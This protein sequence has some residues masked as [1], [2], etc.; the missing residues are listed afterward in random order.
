MIEP[1]GHSLRSGGRR[2]RR[3]SVM[4]F[5]L[6][7]IVV[8]AAA[9]LAF[10][11]RAL[12]EMAG[13][14]Y[15]IQRSR[16]RGEAYSALEATL[17]VLADFR[18]ID[19]GIF[20]PAQGWSDPLTYAGYQ[21]A[22]G[23]TVTVEFSDENAKLALQH[24]DRNEAA[25]IALFTDLGFDTKEVEILTD[26]LLDWIDSDDNPRPVGAEE[27]EYSREDPAYVPA[28]RA[29]RTFEELAAVRGF[30]DLMFTDTGYPTP[31]FE[32]FKQRT[33][34]YGAGVLNLNTASEDV[35]RMSGLFGDN[36]LAALAS[37]LDTVNGPR[38]SAGARFYKSMQD[39]V[40]QTGPLPAGSAVSV[41]CQVLNILITVREGQAVFRLRAVI[42]TDATGTSA[43]SGG[44]N[45]SSRATSPGANRSTV[46]G[47]VGAPAQVEYPFRFLE[48]VEDPPPTNIAELVST[49]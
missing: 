34:L 45:T 26:S 12:N 46:G 16:L 7:L 30:G 28:N 15:Y 33:S 1:G 24:A 13:E 3:G 37:A 36:Q 8:T 25:M 9:I 42:R 40:A 44:Q 27:A 29:P 41:R 6:V 43:T 5:V 32:A 19:G 35:L 23:R 17:G 31:R 4:L 18:A 11:E 21:A 47:T 20:G 22:E 49:P 38:G 10:S 39:L 2:A 14:G 48:L